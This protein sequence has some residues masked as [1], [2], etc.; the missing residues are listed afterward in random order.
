M[1]VF[2][3][4]SYS[5]DGLLALIVL[6]SCT[7]AAFYTVSIEVTFG[8]GDLLLLASQAV[9]SAV[10]KEQKLQQLSKWKPSQTLLYPLRDSSYG[11]VALW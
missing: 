3:Y 10:A 7:K 11:L 1:T 6:P 8:N 4:A 2:V 5:R 9:E